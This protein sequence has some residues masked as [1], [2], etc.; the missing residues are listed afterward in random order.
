MEVIKIGCRTTC[1]NSLGPTYVG[2][3]K[4]FWNSLQSNID[5]ID[6][7]GWPELLELW[8][9][10][11]CALSV[12]STTCVSMHPGKN[13]KTHKRS[14]PMRT[15][16]HLFINIIIILLKSSLLYQY[17]HYFINIII[18]LSILSLFNYCINIIIILS[19][20]S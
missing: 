19:I 4:L 10:P 6:F 11:V 14:T 9:H 7:P 20:L 18:I 12:W 17:Y 16:Y 2:L 13:H 1:L 15:I 5:T 3:S 8:A